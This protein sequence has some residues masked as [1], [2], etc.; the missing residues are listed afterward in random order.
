MS[1]KKNSNNTNYNKLSSADFSIVETTSTGYHL[2][3]KELCKQITFLSVW[4]V[5]FFYAKWS[6]IRIDETKEVYIGCCFRLLI[7]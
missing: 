7:L 4:R 3:S 2:L 5:T 6:P 1:Y